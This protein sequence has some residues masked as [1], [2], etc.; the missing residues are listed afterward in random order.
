MSKPISPEVARRILNMH[1]AGY[2]YDAIRRSTGYSEKACRT[3][4]QGRPQP[5]SSSFGSYQRY[6]DQTAY[7]AEAWERK[8]PEAERMLR[9]GR[10]PVQI[11]ADLGVSQQRVMYLRTDI[12]LSPTAIRAREIA[13]RKE[14]RAAAKLAALTVAD[15]P[16]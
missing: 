12:G 3:V 2:G 7:N 1:H 15:C 11:A 16:K 5:K 9:A 13:A 4:I 6:K 8:K 10:T 14:A